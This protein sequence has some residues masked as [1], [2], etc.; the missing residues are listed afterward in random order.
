MLIILLFHANHLVVNFKN[1]SNTMLHLYNYLKLHIAYY[2]EKGILPETKTFVEYIL[3]QTTSL[4]RPPTKVWCPQLFIYPNLIYFLA[5]RGVSCMWSHLAKEE[6]SARSFCHTVISV[7]TGN[8]KLWTSKS[9]AEN[10]NS[11][12][13]SVSLN[14]I[15]LSFGSVERIIILKFV[16]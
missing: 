4:V 9:L 12:N 2:M 15:M 8:W 16:Y 11:A 5:S 1:F 6:I 10:I 3:L 7:V 14:S 13:D